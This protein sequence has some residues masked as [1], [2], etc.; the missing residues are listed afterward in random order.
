MNKNSKSTFKKI[1]KYACI[2]LIFA[3]FL[4]ASII[5]YSNSLTRNAKEYIANKYGVTQSEITEVE[6]YK[7]HIE[8]EFVLL[9]KFNIWVVPA[10]WVF[11]V[12]GK[13]FNVEYFQKHYVDDFQLEDLEIWCTEYLQDNVDS[14]ISGIELYSDMIF[15]DNTYDMF[16]KRSRYYTVRSSKSLSYSDNK[17]WKQEDI[18][19]FLNYQFDNYKHLGVFYKTDN[20]SKYS[21]T[22]INSSYD[23]LVQTLNHNATISN[24]TLTPILYGGTLELVRNKDCL[25]LLYNKSGTAITVDDTDLNDVVYNFA[26]YKRNCYEIKLEKHS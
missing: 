8:T 21:T 1:K 7:P 5:L 17:L 11:N 9:E 2:A 10:K 24:C 12:D 13:N 26:I 16:S 25:Y 14:N 19:E 15:H 4:A 23:N 3:I 6:E 18:S 20:I 22:D